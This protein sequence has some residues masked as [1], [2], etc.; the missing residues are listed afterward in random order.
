[1]AIHCV[2]HIFVCWL[3]LSGRAARRS[4]RLDH[5]KGSYIANR[6]VTSVDDAQNIRCSTRVLVASFSYG[7][8]EEES[9]GKALD[10]NKTHTTNPT[11]P[12]QQATSVAEPAIQR[13]FSHKSL[14]V[15]LAANTVI[16]RASCYELQLLV[17]IHRRQ[18]GE[19]KG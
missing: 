14:S 12:P 7:L 1:M 16:P 9:R 13:H 5:A 3:W 11:A 6:W 2:L 19:P 15:W 10:Q 17:I 4:E 8:S 18:N